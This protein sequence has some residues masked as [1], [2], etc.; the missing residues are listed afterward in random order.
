MNALLDDL[1]VV[2]VAKKLGLNL[3]EGTNPCPV[4]QQNGCFY[5]RENF[6]RC[7][8]P[9]CGVSGNGLD[10]IQVVGA[11]RS[12][13][14]AWGWLAK[15]L[16]NPEL[17]WQR[18]QTLKWVF[19]HLQR[20]RELAVPYLKERGLLQFAHTGIY[21]FGAEE[22]LL[23][24]GDYEQLQVCG[25]IDSNG[26]S[27]LYNRVVFPVYTHQR[28]LIHFQSRSIDGA[29]PLRWR[30]TKTH[31]CAPINHYVYG[32]ESLDEKADVLFLCEG[33]TDCLSLREL[34]LNALGTFGLEPRLRHLSPAALIA[35]Y[36]SDMQQQEGQSIYKSWSRILKHLVHWHCENGIPVG[37][38]MPP[39]ND[40]NDWLRQGL[41]KETFL[42]YC[43]KQLLPLV[44]AVD[45]WSPPQL[46]SQ[47]LLQ[48]YKVGSLE[49]KGKI[50]SDLD[51]FLEFL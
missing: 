4:C 18:I 12:R 43:E 3:K 14:E 9:S 30:A 25:L 51:R 26:K 24:L 5:V 38:V 41:T 40:L 1:D 46:R 34:G 19:A 49:A 44:E 6:F 50:L 35:V 47:L 20:N 13:S 23:H 16:R 2:T 11:A 8:R 29:E 7:Y 42:A 36:D 45:L 10:L 28:Q 48:L 27:T 31:Q 37:C 21:G 39:T 22:S 15:T 17:W 32:L 33:I